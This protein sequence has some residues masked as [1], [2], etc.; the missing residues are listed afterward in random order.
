MSPAALK[1]LSITGSFDQPTQLRIHL[2]KV[3]NR[4][5]LVAKADGVVFWE[6]A[7]VCG[8]GKGEWKEASYFPQWDTYQNVYDRDYQAI[9]LAGTKRVELSVN[10]SA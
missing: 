2:D 4:A 6:Q 3:S 7:F 9:I 8:P 10:E 1:P 5:T